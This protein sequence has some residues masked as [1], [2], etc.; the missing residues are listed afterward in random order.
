MDKP[1]NV[2]CISNRDLSGADAL[3]LARLER[4]FGADPVGKRGE[5]VEEA[6]LRYVAQ[7]RDYDGPP[8]LRPRFFL[9]RPEDMEANGVVAKSRIFPREVAVAGGRIVVMALAGVCV[10]PAVR[11]T[12][13]GRAVVEAAFALVDGGVFLL[14]LFEAPERVRPFYEKLGA[15]AVENRIVNSLAEDP[16]QNPFRDEVVLRYPANAPWPEG[17]I[18]LLGP[19]Y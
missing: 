6:G 7:G 10:D 4:T 3:A 18:D 15:C 19:G 13:L 1:L 16:L 11:G 8:A 2:E 14:A 12:G 5:T 9:V 17:E